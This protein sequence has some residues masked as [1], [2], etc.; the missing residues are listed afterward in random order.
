MIGDLENNILSF[1]RLDC[2]QNSLFFFL[3]LR[4]T[5]EKTFMDCYVLIILQSRVYPNG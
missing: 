1:P 2:H 5:H 3:P 4:K